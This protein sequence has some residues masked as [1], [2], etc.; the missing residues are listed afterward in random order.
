MSNVINMPPPGG[1]PPAQQSYAERYR[2]GLISKA[3]RRARV[4]ELLAAGL[5]IEATAEQVGMSASGVAGIRKSELGK[6]ARVA[7]DM[8]AELRQLDLVRIEAGIRAIWPSVLKGNLAAIDRMDKLVRTRQSILGKPDDNDNSKGDHFHFHVSKGDVQEVERAVFGDS[9][10]GE[11]VE[12]PAG[13]L[14][15]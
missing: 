13:E 6:L 5:S 3:Q 11:A 8:A 12:I 9:I 2:S 4:M 1:K 10:P 14:G 7:G 15:A